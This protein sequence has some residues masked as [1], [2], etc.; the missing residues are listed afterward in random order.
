[1]GAIQSTLRKGLTDMFSAFKG[2]K[3]ATLAILG[4]DSSGKS[5]LVNLFNTKS[6]P[7]L[8]TMGFSF[9]EITFANTTIKIWDIGGQKEFVAYWKQYVDDI[10]GMV[11]MIDIADEKRFRDS[12]EGFKLL[13][14][15]LKDGLSV[16]LFLNKTDLFTDMAEVER[17]AAEIEKMYHVDNTRSS[18][19]SY[20]KIGEK[21]FKTRVSKISVK[22]D[23]E[24]MDSDAT[25]TIQHA[26]VHSGFKWLVDDVNNNESRS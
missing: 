15:H 19:D 13:S 18:V 9:E 8:P 20:M 25:Y 5:T 10:D 26:S 23:L 17:R 3:K 16:L 12:Y 6:L 24:I 4:L 21:T 2:K 11:F 7:T 22:N 1:M 14:P